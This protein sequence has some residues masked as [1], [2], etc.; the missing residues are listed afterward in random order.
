M[1]NLNPND[2]IKRMEAQR[3]ELSQSE[4]NIMRDFLVEHENTIKNLQLT[5]RNLIDIL[6]NSRGP[7]RTWSKKITLP[8]M[9]KIL[10]SKKEKRTRKMKRSSMI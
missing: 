6:E 7:S 4:K 2:R 3:R 5:N 1:E 9:E 8:I 10:S